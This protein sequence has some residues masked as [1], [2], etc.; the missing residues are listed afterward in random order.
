ML[1]LINVLTLCLILTRTC[2]VCLNGRL[3]NMEL[4]GKGSKKDNS[5]KLKKT[6]KAQKK[7]LNIHCKHGSNLIPASETVCRY[8]HVDHKQGKLVIK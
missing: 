3:E 8:Y 2:L 5:V 1:T 4:S 7:C 6:H